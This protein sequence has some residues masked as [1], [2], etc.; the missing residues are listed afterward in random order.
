VEFAGR[1][2]TNIYDYMNILEPL[3]AGRQ[4][5]VIVHRDNQPVEL[6]VIPTTRK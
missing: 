1:K 3:N 5:K 6:N 2:V 4:Y